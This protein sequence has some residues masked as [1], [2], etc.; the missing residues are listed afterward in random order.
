MVIV[1]LDLDKLT[2]VTT[3]CYNHND[4][5]DPIRIK[6][7]ETGTIIKAWMC[8]HSGKTITLCVSKYL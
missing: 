8:V 2:I 6:I 3:E 1:E 5:Q 7:E 4:P